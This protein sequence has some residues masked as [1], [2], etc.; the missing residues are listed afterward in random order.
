MHRISLPTFMFLSL[1]QCYVKSMISLPS[2]RMATVKACIRCHGKKIRCSGYPSCQTC[3]KAGVNCEPYTRHR[4]GDSLG[5]LKYYRQRTIWLEDEVYRNFHIQCRDVPTGT[6]LQPAQGGLISGNEQGLPV[7]LSSPSLASSS[8]HHEIQDLS[9]EVSRSSDIGILALNATGEMKYLGPSSGAFFAAYTS[10]LARSCILT[11]NTWNSTSTAQHANTGLRADV[12]LVD[13]LVKFSSNDVNLFLQSYKMWIQPL[14][15]ILNSDDLD[16]IVSRYSE[17][18]GVDSLNCEEWP[19]RST[20]L[21]LFYL[22]M[23]LGAINAT[24]TL[25]EFRRQLEQE[26]LIDMQSTRPSPVLLCTQ[27]L[28]LMDDNFQKLHPSVGF[29]QVI[30]MISIYSSYGP[31]GSGQWQLA[32]LAMRMAIEMGL[33]YTPKTNNHSDSAKGQRS[34]IFWTIY[35]IEISLAYNLGRPPSIGAEHIAV[36]L[37]E[38][39]NENLLSLHHIR[40]RQI[41]SKVVTQ[42][43]GVNHQTRNMTTEQKQILISSVQEELDKWRTNIPVSP[44]SGGVH[45]YPYCYWDRLYH[46]T[47]F[48]LHRSSPLCPSPPAQSLE[49]CIRSAGSYIDDMLKIL[50]ASNVPLSWMLAQGV[51]FAGLTM[52]V[53]ARTGLHRLLP[54]VGAAF[55]LVDLH[56]WTRNCSICLAI[57]NERLREDLLSKLDSQFELLANDTLRTISTN[58][59]SQATNK[60]SHTSEIPTNIDEAEN[61]LRSEQTFI[62]N[63]LSSDINF[64]EDWDYFDLFKEFMGQDPAQTF[65]DVFPPDLDTDSLAGV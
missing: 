8:T 42:I 52:L 31:I 60:S 10:A 12:S 23:A 46:G 16:I 17:D 4:K 1:A 21:M 2:P 14:Y 9:A 48:V 51:L 36:E 6:S 47:T 18:P 28:Q 44:H 29:I 19:E 30:L 35:A 22:V 59:T 53:T 40:H 38:P 50:R 56:S 61:A 33:H 27:V 49:L 3:A 5:E 41:Q 26:E 39:L 20:K 25:K 55:L 62:T 34:R 13:S 64:A 15:P 45:P 43:Y 24:N 32:G 54:H 7:Q 63:A 37:P 65:W 57:M 58:L 11:K